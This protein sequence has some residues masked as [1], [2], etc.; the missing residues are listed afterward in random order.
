[1]CL[2]VMKR[3]R[4]S[5]LFTKEDIKHFSLSSLRPTP[6]HK[7]RFEYLVDWDPSSLKFLSDK[8]QLCL[9]VAVRLKSVAESFAMVLQAGLKHYPEELGL[10]FEKNRKG[11]TACEL[12]FE[13]YGKDE[14]GQS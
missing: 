6:R 9:H 1:M 7:A 13:K 4:Q 8:G 12:A 14:I 3:L 2:I 5:N 10:L 11:K